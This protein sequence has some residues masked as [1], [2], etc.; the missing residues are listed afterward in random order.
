VRVSGRAEL[1]PLR[2][3]GGAELERVDAEVGTVQ[4]GGHQHLEPVGRAPEEAAV[5]LGPARGLL[6]RQLSGDPQRVGA[7]ALDPS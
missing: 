5:Q 3:A 7:E 6:D 2:H 4:V 1:H